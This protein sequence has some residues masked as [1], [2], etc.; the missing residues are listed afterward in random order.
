M[1][2]DNIAPAG[3]KA[4]YFSAQFRLLRG[5][6]PAGQRQPDDAPRP[7]AVVLIIA[8]VSSPRTPDVKECGLARTK[9]SPANYRVASGC[10]ASGTGLTLYCRLLI[11]CHLR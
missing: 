1:L 4:S 6:K 11:R 8:I 2:I 5:G 9:L 10:A 7:A 3:M